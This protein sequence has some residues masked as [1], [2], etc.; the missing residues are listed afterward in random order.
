MQEHELA[1]GDTLVIAGVGRV[2]LKDVEGD[3][4]LLAVRLLD[5]AEEARLRGQEE[6]DEVLG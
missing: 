2:T 3:A 1:V 4:A 5:E 6:A